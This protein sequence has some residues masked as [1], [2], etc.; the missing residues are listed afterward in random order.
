MFRAPDGGD[1]ACQ[2]CP[3]QPLAREESQ[4]T[5]DG[6]RWV[7]TAHQGKL[8]RPAA[9]KISNLHGRE[10]VPVDWLIGKNTD[11]QSPCFSSIM[12]ARSRCAAALSFQMPIKVGEH[13]FDW[14]G[15]RYS[16]KRPQ[17]ILSFVHCFSLRPG[18]SQ[19]DTR[20][21]MPR[22]SNWGGCRTHV[23]QHRRQ[24]YTAVLG[25]IRHSA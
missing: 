8:L 7:L 25:I 4:Q 16:R 2:S 15:R 17:L 18:W 24:I 22:K 3:N 10:V 19:G 14:S 12:L 5:P 13:L 20:R 23:P 9:D 11:Q 1:G 21:I 6:C